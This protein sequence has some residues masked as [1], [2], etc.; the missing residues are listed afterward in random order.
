[1]R[2]DAEMTEAATGGTSSGSRLRERVAAWRGTAFGPASELPYRRRTSDVVRLIVTVTLLVLVSLH[3]GHP[4]DFENDLFKLVNGLP[5]QLE[6][7]FELLY[8]LGAL[9]AL[10]LIV[11]AALVARR[12]RLARD[13]LVAGVVTWVLGRLIGSLVVTDS[14]L[15]D[16]LDVVTRFGKAS[17]S[18]PVVRLAMIA[19]VISVATP[20][21]GRPTR[22]MGQLLVLVLAFASLYLGTGLPDAAFA[23]LVLGWGVAALVHLAFG[24]PGGRPTS[25]QVEVALVELGLRSP[26]VHLADPQPRNGTA[27]E[28]HDD[29]GPLLVRVLG[30]DEAD[31]QLAAKA[32]RFLVYKDGGPNVHLTRLGE[33]EH[34]AYVLLLAQRAGVTVPAV[35]VAGTAGPGAALLVSRP[36]GGRPLCDLDPAALTDGVL[37]DLWHQL[38]ALHAAHVA[39]GA[40]TARRVVLTDRGVAFTGFDE[41][42]GR[43]SALERSADV[44]EVLFST[45]E[46]VGADRAIAAARGGVGDDGVVAA[47]P[48]LQP[49]ALSGETR[50]NDPRQRKAFGKRVGDLRSAAATATGTE[51]PA[52]QQLHRV[53]GTS[54]MMAVGTLF[55]ISVLLSQVGDPETLWDTI[56]SANLWWLTAAMLISFATNCATAIALMGTVPINLPLWRTSELQLSMSFSNLAIPAVGGMAAQIRFLQKQGVDLAS[57]VASGG[58]LINA[59]NI[60]ANTV[61]LFIAIALSPDTFRAQSIPV[62]SIVEVV[63]LALLAL[64][65]VSGLAFGI[66]RLRRMVLPPLKS[67]TSTILAATRS[68]KRVALLLGGN[69]INAI[70]YGAVMYCCVEAFGGSI[71]F[72]TLLALNIFIGTIAS[73]VPIPGGN[74]AVSTVGMSGALT[75]FGV[76]TEVAV[77]A[78]LAN[79]LVANY[80]PAIPGWFAT[81]NMLHDD[82]L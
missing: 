30:R 61:L 37:D 14:S 26:D 66:P 35:V 4:T 73:L 56:T 58:L 31:A 63:V 6:T 20:Y 36:L 15:I 80:I 49:T 78:V 5:D 71:N 59:G 11:L 19:A 57:A 27:M 24:S 16:S 82:Y 64:A 7:L 60:L 65:V 55:A 77:A 76:S 13:M 42:T 44:A 3:E 67:A 79:Q 8:R 46:L 74:T 38:G 33:V 47:L 62:S 32:W 54:L 23:A 25:R 50:P 39:H 1:M 75:A 17:P 40:L 9:W 45:S 29:D 68:P 81:N 22:R 51:P 18:F 72:F 43:A 48:V 34:E 21:L 12:W 70:M 69:T 53:S 2:Q 41:A 28:G 10:G 52:L